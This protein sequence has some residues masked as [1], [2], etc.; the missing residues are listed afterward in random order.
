MAFERFSKLP[1]ELRL[2][3]WIYCLPSPQI[4]NVVAIT[5]LEEER[6]SF[7][8]PVW[9]EKH[10]QVLYGHSIPRSSILSPKLADN[11]PNSRRTKIHF[12]YMHATGPQLNPLMQVSTESRKVL[13]KNCLN[14]PTARL[15]P[16]CKYILSL[17][18]IYTDTAFGMGEYIS[19]REHEAYFLNCFLERGPLTT[20]T[21]RHDIL[22]LADPPNID[23]SGSSEDLISSLEILLRWLDSSVVKNIRYLS[24]PYATWRRDHLSGDL[25]RLKEFEK[26]EKIWVCFVGETV[27]MNRESAGWISLV[28]MGDSSVYFRQAK[29][30]VLGDWRDLE[31]DWKGIGLNPPIVEML[32]DKKALMKLV[33]DGQTKIAGF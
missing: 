31:D 4:L 10:S 5:T 33:E 16:G 22:F 17:Q 28:R 26:L 11:V 15:K 1:L 21:P 32:S 25:K 20:F 23:A 14:I 7:Q 18:D 12:Q 19:T 6:V 24:M 27:E 9:T 30:Q 2:K 13:S 3:I 8:P 29:E